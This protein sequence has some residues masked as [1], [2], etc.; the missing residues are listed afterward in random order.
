MSPETTPSTSIFSI[1]PKIYWS[2][3]GNLPILFIPLLIMKNRAAGFSSMDIWFAAA[4]LAL[5]IA[6][7]L[8]ARFFNPAAPKE[9]RK[10]FVMLTVISGGMLA[11]GHVAAAVMG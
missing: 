3:I 11:A 9:I 8:D 1:I 2:S 5:G 4:F 7:L 6:R 10:Y